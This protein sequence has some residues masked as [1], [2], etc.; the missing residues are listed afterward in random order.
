MN[1]VKRVE[2][3]IIK[4]LLGVPKRCKTTAI[5]LSLNI[6]PTK[7]FLE[8]QKTEFYERFITNVFT[9]NLIIELAN[10][11]NDRDF[12]TEGINITDKIEGLNLEGLSLL[13]KCKLINE[14][15]LDQFTYERKSNITSK[16]L[17]EVYEIKDKSK[18]VSQMFELCRYDA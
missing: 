8:N 13:N 9:K 12:I 3:N 14:I 1:E 5:F 7:L 4:R 2:G 6:M 15:N 17:K 11:Q 10:Y 16:K 18:I